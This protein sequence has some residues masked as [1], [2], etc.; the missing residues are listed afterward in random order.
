M[1][2]RVIVDVRACNGRYCYTDTAVYLRGNHV[3]VQVNTNDVIRWVTEV[4]IAGVDT[5]DE[6][7]RSIKDIRQRH[8]T[9]WDEG[10][11]PREWKNYLKEENKSCNCVFSLLY[12]TTA[13]E[14]TV[15]YY[16]QAGL[17]LVI[18]ILVYRYRLIQ[19]YGYR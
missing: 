17:H 15:C 12:K 14:N 4:E 10:T 7:T 3:C 5:N 1:H 6:R 8:G 2:Y 18:S 19:K 16:V 13:V 9:Q 11:L